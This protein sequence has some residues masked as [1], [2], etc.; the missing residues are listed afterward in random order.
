[1]N[2]V[3]VFSTQGPKGGDIANFLGPDADLEIVGWETDTQTAL[4]RI[5]EIHPDVTILINLVPDFN[6]NPLVKMVL[7][8]YPQGKVV[9]LTPTSHVLHV[10]E[11]DESPV[12]EVHD[13]LVALRQ[14]ASP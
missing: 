11:T 2:Q 12:R 3:F 10:Y 4:D 6:L 14:I 8:E 9:E 7:S 1:M 5:R 13:L